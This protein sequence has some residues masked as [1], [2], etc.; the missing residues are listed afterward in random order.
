MSE[1]LKYFLIPVA[2]IYVCCP[3][4]GDIYFREEQTLPLIGLQCVASVDIH[5]MDL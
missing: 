5:H 2:P 3:F 1:L 4:R